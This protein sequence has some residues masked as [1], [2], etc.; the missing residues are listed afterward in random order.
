MIRSSSSIKDEIS[1]PVDYAKLIERNSPD[2]RVGM[3][4]R[5]HVVTFG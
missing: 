3:A 1:M 2:V 5:S 4:E